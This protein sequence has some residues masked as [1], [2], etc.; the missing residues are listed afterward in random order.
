MD[1]TQIATSVES[2]LG[3]SIK[4]SSNYS[5]ILTD[6]A[7]EMGPDKTRTQLFSVL[8]QFIVTDREEFLP[9]LCRELGKIH[10]YIGGYEHIDTLLPLLEKLS[11][12]EE[13]NIR[14]MTVESLLTIFED[15]KA[16]QFRKFINFI[17]KLYNSEW[18]TNRATVIGLLSVAYEASTDPQDR[19]DICEIFCQLARDPMVLVRRAAAEKLGDWIT[20]DGCCVKGFVTVA[21]AVHVKKNLVPVLIELLQ[22]FQDSVKV[23]A[24]SSSPSVLN[25][26]LAV[27]HVLPEEF[28]TSLQAVFDDPSWRV[29]CMVAETLPKLQCLLQDSCA[30]E[31]FLLDTFL[32]LL[33]DK[34]VD[35]RAIASGKILQFC[36][37][38]PSDVRLETTHHVIFPI[39]EKLISD[40]AH[41]VRVALASNLPFLSPILGRDRSLISIIP[42][43]H[44]LLSD[45]FPDVKLALLSSMHVV[46][47]VLEDFSFDTLIGET[48]AKLSEDK[49]WRVR[50]AVIKHSPEMSKILASKGEDLFADLIEKWLLDCVYSVREAAADIIRELA[51]SFGLHWA[52][53]K[54]FPKINR[55]CNNSNYLYR[56]TA[57]SLINK[58]LPL[59]TLEII[60]TSV[61]PLLF[62]LGND[63]VANVRLNVAR[64]FGSIRQSLIESGKSL[65][66][67]ETD[68]NKSLENLCK[69]S[70]QDVKLYA[71]Q[72]IVT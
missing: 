27:E 72:A 61:L 32:K 54:V 38:L 50:V 7:I 68:I 55:L 48:I 69:D 66:A 16:T 56:I 57:L 43:L 70:D 35:V 20:T 15:V 53:E 2:L 65:D 28:M 31:N 13:S 8:E 34:E 1:S 36:Q 6:L 59:L 26:L 42:I 60:V 22:D 49:Q 25:S 29:R 51:S 14:K 45:S 30:P 37:N 24:V 64:T 71:Q 19:E 62:A 17:S 9:I 41:E 44:L 21:S 12:S 18:F 39:C 33:C 67:I 4:T 23:L 52:M 10:E 63:P 47:D 3:E 40:N 46:K 11:S 58:L 5:N